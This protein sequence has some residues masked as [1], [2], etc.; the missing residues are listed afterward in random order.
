M[1]EKDFK[2]LYGSIW[3]AKEAGIS[4]RQ[5]YHWVDDL[6]VVRPHLWQHGVRK[7]RRFSFEDLEKLKEMRKRVEQG[8]TPRAAAEAVKSHQGSGC[9]N[10]K[11][12]ARG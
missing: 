11:D 2:D 3:A 8:Y 9:G 12:E 7:F 10:G 5:L 4:L 1:S 6:R